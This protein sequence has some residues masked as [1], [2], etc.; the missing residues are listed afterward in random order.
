MI[1]I[2]ICDDQAIVREGLKTIISTDPEIT[3]IATSSDGAELLNKLSSLQ[4]DEL[5]HLVL[6][7]LKMPVVNGIRAAQEIGS[8]Y[9]AVKTLVL[10]TYDE[11]QW[12]F[13]AIRAGA[14][15]YILKDTPRE[16]LID[17][18]KG[19]A[20]GGTYVDPSIAGKVL[21]MVR[22]EYI[23]RNSEAS[24]S[25]T[26][27]EREMIILIARGY[28]NTEI[29]EKLFLSA[30]TVRNYTSSIFSKLNVADRTQ[31]T[32]AALRNGLIRLEDI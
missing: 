6:L 26:D 29:G 2:I 15:G 10:T 32:V 3:V 4:G 20:A 21:K 5:P 13:D 8:R 1:R 23:P 27:R 19:T 25:F 9:P 7:D 14:S 30:G 28:S 11:D 12:V 22:G 18:I 31:A 16:S 17:A 24:D